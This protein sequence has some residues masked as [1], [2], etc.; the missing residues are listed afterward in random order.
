[1][2]QQNAIDLDECGGRVR[3]VAIAGQGPMGTRNRAPRHDNGH[4]L[5]WINRGGGRVMLDGLQHGFGP[6]SAIFVP[7]HTVYQLDLSLGAAGWQVSVPVDLSAPLPQAPVL[8]S[9]TKPLVQN[10][11]T[12]AFVA[13]QDEFIGHD[14]HRG[15]AMAYSVGMLAILFARMDA[16]TTRKDVSKDSARRRLMRS[17]ITRLNERYNTADTVRDYA[18]ELGVTTTHL[19]RIC[20]ET[21]GKPATQM[22]QDKT[23]EAARQML[24]R[25]NTKIGQISSQLGFSSPAYFTRLFSEKIGQ[26]PKAYRRTHRGQPGVTHH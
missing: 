19:T 4:Q 10:L 2:T 3:S 24:A 5:I 6:N 9:V 11:M 13:I 17:F 12:K 15:A 7:A 16:E 23:L 21:S 8:A 25:S 1:M 22:I 18:K 14:L 20:R 26:S